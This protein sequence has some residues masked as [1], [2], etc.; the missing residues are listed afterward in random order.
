MKRNKLLALLVTGA[1]TVGVVGATMAY[2]VSK[3]SVTNA[4]TTAKTGVD[5]KEEFDK[6]DAENVKPGDEVNKDVKV[7]NTANYNQFI[8]VKLTP[9]FTDESAGLDVSKIQLIFKDSL[10]DDMSTNSWVKGTDGYYYYIGKLAPNAATEELLDAVKL[11]LKDVTS[12]DEDKY[13]DKAYTVTV[14]AEGVQ[15][16]SNAFV[17][18]WGVASDSDIGRVLVGL[19]D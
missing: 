10:K 17:D 16:D 7:I 9:K 8:R 5:V 14:E 4:F 6:E 12:A 15:A 1:L 13:Q 18:E 19:Q 11:D 2:F 3:D